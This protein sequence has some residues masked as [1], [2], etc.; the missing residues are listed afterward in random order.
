MRGEKP[1]C[2]DSCAV[3]VVVVTPDANKNVSA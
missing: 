2:P 3:V 1:A